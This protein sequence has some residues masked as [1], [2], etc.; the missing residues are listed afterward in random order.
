MKNTVLVAM[1]SSLCFF[2]LFPSLAEGA[3][4]CDCSPKRGAKPYRL[5]AKTETHFTSFAKSGVALTPSAVHG[6]EKKYF[7]KVNGNTVAKTTKRLTGTP[8]DSLYTLD[9]YMWYV[10]KEEDC[11]YHI[12]I[13]S[14]SKQSKKRAVVEVCIENCELQK[15][16]KDTMDARG[17][18]FGKEF[19]QGIPV[20]VVGLGFYDWQH[21]L[22]PPPKKAKPESPLRKQ[23][24]TAW[25][26]HPVESI[27]FK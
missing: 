19:A 6:W 3:D 15:V 26:L 10:A 20:T 18:A 8:E 14:K 21:K 4:P 23:E 22:K 5:A 1:L 12:Q 11:D 13:G 24:G 27:R 25:E 9:G 7:K 2:T 16:I 17:Y